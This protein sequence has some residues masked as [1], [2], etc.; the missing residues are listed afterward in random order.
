[1]ARAWAEPDAAARGFFDAVDLVAAIA[2]RS[3]IFRPGARDCIAARTIFSA[4]GL[5][6]V[7]SMV[8]E[9][10]V[11]MERPAPVRR[12]SESTMASAAVDWLFAAM[13][14][15]TAACWRWSGSRDGADL[16]TA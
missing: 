7:G 6:T 15:S 13:R 3:V 9:C 5:M 2:G 8:F 11:W 14:A 10:V 4:S 1:M 16:M 12:K